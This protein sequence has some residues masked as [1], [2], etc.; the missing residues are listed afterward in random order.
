M[1]D[2]RVRAVPDLLLITEQR[3][4]DQIELRTWLPAAMRRITRLADRIGGIVSAAGL[5]FLDHN[6]TG[7][8]FIV[9][10]D[11]DPA[12]AAVPVEVGAPVHQ[13]STAVA[14]RRDPAHREA[15]VRNPRRTRLHRADR[16]GDHEIADAARAIYCA[17]ELLD[18]AWP[19]R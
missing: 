19:I 10:Y 18:F 6:G 5:P 13:E 14:M 8:V 7:P 3:H 16:I 1:S 12:E 2:I 11:G 15:Y 4:V 17:G 9:I